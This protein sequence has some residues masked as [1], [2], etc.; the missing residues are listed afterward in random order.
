M[1]KDEEL[2]Q[3]RQEQRQLRGTEAEI[4][5]HYLVPAVFAFFFCSGRGFAGAISS[6]W[7]TVPRGPTAHRRSDRALCVARAI[8]SDRNVPF[9]SKARQADAVS[10]GST[11]TCHV[12]IPPLE[13][14]LRPQPSH[15]VP[16]ARSCDERRSG[17]KTETARCRR[18]SCTIPSGDVESL[19]IHSLYS[20][21]SISCT[22]IAFIMLPL[23]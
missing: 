2:D 22:E 14:F 17:Q 23:V 12:R 10:S 4:Y 21:I 18:D 15:P 1:T 16:T 20:A 3:L 19:A 9:A 5:E 13:P 6:G 7:G 8:C 11:R